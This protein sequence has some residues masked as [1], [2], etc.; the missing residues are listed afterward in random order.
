MDRVRCDN[1]NRLSETVQ[2][3]EIKEVKE[4]KGKAKSAESERQI[5]SP[6]SRMLA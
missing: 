4:E 3:E 1:N 2:P 5:S 6:P